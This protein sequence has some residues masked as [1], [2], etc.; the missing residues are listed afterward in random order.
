GEQLK[1]K[2]AHFSAERRKILHDSLRSQYGSLGISPATERNLASL[3]SENTFTVTTGHQLNLFTGPLYFIYKIATVINTCKR[4]SALHP[5]KQFVP[6]Y[7]MA[8]ED[9]DFEEIRS[10][11]L[12]NKKFTWQTGQKGAVGR[13]TL[14]DLQPLLKEIPGDITM[15]REA[16]STSSTL[17]EAV[18]HYV[19]ALFSH[20][21]IVV[22]DGD[23]AQLKQTFSHV[24]EEDILY[25][26]TRRLVEQ[27]NGQLESLGYEPQVFVRD[28][29]FFWLGDGSRERIEKTGET[30]S[31]LNGGPAF[32]EEQLRSAIRETPER[33]S[34]NVILRPLYQETILPNLAYVGG[35]AENVY[36]LQL[37]SVF[38][39]FNVP[40]PML[41]PRNFVMVMDG[42]TA[43]LFGKTGLNAAELFLPK[44]A[45][46][47]LVT[48]RCSE[49][50]LNL[51]SE[52][53]AS[54]S[55]FEH[56][57]KLA[58]AIDPT[59]DKMVEAEQHRRLKG[60]EIIEK[61]ML[62][63]ERRRQSD[64]LRQVETL[65]DNLFPG[66]GLQERTDNLL[67][68]SQTDPEFVNKILTALDPFEYAFNLLSV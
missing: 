52:K 48:I 61:K 43:R 15:F 44:S 57:R 7:W 66:G 18:R 31:V 1:E 50:T 17:A 19:N 45:L 16:Y 53:A 36:W 25:G 34:P 41:M 2:S 67:L 58:G 13:F 26:T 29:N 5:D 4:L 68:F 49:H 6:V 54:A 12:G 42:P 59:L 64:R 60:L 8:S 32:S 10:F 62:R 63:A 35:P 33:L 20:E 38:R 22:I 51:E 3:L 40:F 56:I 55:T 65:K 37:K 30:W 24:M 14:K 46:L 9:H 39:H 47:N 23:D 11:K 28:V 27:T 21:G